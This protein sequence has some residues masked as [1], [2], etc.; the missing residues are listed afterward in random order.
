MSR[1]NLTMSQFISISIIFGCVLMAFPG[2]NPGRVSAQGTNNGDVIIT[3]PSSQSH[4]GGSGSTDNFTDS[5]RSQPL[6]VGDFNGDGIEDL[7]VGAPDATV[8]AGSEIRGFAGMVFIVLGGS[9]RSQ[10]IDTV[11]GASNTPDIKILGPGSAARMGWSLASGDINGDGI[12][13]LAIGAPEASALGRDAAGAVYIMLGSRSFSSHLALDFAQQNAADFIIVG[14][15]QSNRFGA[16]L[17]VGN[18]GGSAADDI[19]IGAPGGRSGS[20]GGAAYLVFGASTLGGSTRVLD[21]STSSA[22]VSLV[23]GDRQRVGTSVVIADLNGDGAGDIFTGAPGS[24]RPVGSVAP[25]FEAGAVFGFLGPVS[26]GLLVN[27]GSNQHV[28]SFYGGASGDHFG[29]ALAAGDLSADGVTDLVVGAPGYDALDGFQPDAGAV[30]VFAGNRALTQSR[31]DVAAREH[32]LAVVSG[33]GKGFLGFSVAVGHWDVSDDNN[34]TRDLFIGGPGALDGSGFAVVLFGGPRFFRIQE[35]DLSLP[36][37]RGDVTLF[38]PP[39]QASLGFSISSLDLDGDNSGDLVVSSPSSDLSGRPE[40]GQVEIRFGTIRRAVPDP[41]QISTTSIA[42]ATRGVIYSQQL[43]ASGGNGPYRWAMTGGSLPAGLTISEAGII[44]GIP[45]ASGN[46]EFTVNVRD[47]SAQTA[48]RSLQ[49][50]VVEPVPVPRITSVKYKTR[51]GKITVTGENINVNAVL[52]VDDQVVSNAV[53]NGGVISAKKVRLSPGA[54][55]IR[56]ENPN[57]VFS[58]PFSLTVR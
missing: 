18:A 11:N 10:V 44:S 56:V 48:S 34:G 13:D 16:S 7:A 14:P 19:L 51:K 49:I 20:G 1:K 43:A 28:V 46:F 17:A 58:D 38:G 33:A 4:L 53:V 47:A 2:L 31:F 50:V 36:S 26:S 27:L 3:G 57:G 32:S 25:A 24:D 54:H 41:V 23:G 5:N 29:M 52:R 21:L 40:A 15:S 6:A 8:F 22:D 45:T 9:E 37:G 30:Y 55:Q 39:G 12:T 42:T 35:R